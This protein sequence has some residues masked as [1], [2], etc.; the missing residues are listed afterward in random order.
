M[1]LASCTPTVPVQYCGVV[2]S[3]KQQP[4]QVAGSTRHYLLIFSWYA[5]P[6]RCHHRNLATS[7]VDRTEVATLQSCVSM[8]TAITR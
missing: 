8:H 1:N 4:C 3:A 5:T 2:A 7:T 6:A